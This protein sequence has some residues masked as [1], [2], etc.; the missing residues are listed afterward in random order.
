[1]DT[2]QLFDWQRA[3]ESELEVRGAAVSFQEPPS[4]TFIGQGIYT[5]G[6]HIPAGTYSFYL[7]Q[8][9]SREASSSS[10]LYLFA[11]QDEYEQ[12]L[13]KNNGRL[14][15]IATF[16]VYRNSPVSCLTLTQGQILAIKYNGVKI[17]KFLLEL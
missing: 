16:S 7:P 5:I 8:F 4:G 17:C 3:V 13:K 15:T 1:M 6:E 2:D 11:N 9:I 10:Y 12:H 14:G